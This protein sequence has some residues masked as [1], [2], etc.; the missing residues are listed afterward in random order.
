MESQTKLLTP[1]EAAQFLRVSIHT[2]R[3]WTFRREIPAV[4]IGRKVLFRLSDLE[5]L[6]NQGLQKVHD[7]EV[8]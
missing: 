4:R 7:E 6:I 2:I 3:A 1:N 8:D 5:E